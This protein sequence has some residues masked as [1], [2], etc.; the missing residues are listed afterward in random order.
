MQADKGSG[1]NSSFFSSEGTFS[2]APQGLSAGHSVSSGGHVIGW[3]AF[4][5]NNLD[6]IPET[7]KVYDVLEGSP[8]VAK[9]VVGAI[10]MASNDSSSPKTYQVYDSQDVTSPPGFVL[11]VQRNDSSSS[12]EGDTLRVTV[13]QSPGV[14]SPFRS[15]PKPQFRGLAF[16][17]R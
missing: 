17:V 12:P 4:G 15:A 3:K 13:A 16:Y 9:Q 11:E 14:Y 8:D 5:D 6:E 7:F 10:V 2:F 1:Y